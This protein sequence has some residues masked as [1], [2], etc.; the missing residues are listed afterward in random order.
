MSV[1]MNDDET[2]DEVLRRLFRILYR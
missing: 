2:T 1:A